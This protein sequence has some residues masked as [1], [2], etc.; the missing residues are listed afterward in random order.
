[1][2][3]T[4]HALSRFDLVK[5][6]GWDICVFNCF[7]IPLAAWLVMSLARGEASLE[8]F[9]V[10][11]KWEAHGIGKKDIFWSGRQSVKMGY[12]VSFSFAPSMCIQGIR[13]YA[14]REVGKH[15]F[16]CCFWK[17]LACGYSHCHLLTVI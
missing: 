3:R 6:R 15:L 10:I 11:C 12:G 4:T 14:R 13:I 2:G 8:C 1:M 7:S 17:L 16:S 5:T 9:V